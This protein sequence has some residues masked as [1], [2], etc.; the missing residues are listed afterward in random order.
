MSKT[1]KTLKVIGHI[2]YFILALSPIFFS[3]L[4]AWN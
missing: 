2:I 4:H 1:K 3:R